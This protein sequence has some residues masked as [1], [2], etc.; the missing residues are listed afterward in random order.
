MESIADEVETISQ[1][2]VTARLT[3][4]TNATRVLHKTA[5][6]IASGESTAHNYHWAS[7]AKSAS[8]W[9]RDLNTET[10]GG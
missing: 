9:Q 4:K 1:E 8:Q 2:T 7:I 10:N 6:V 3:H 5:T